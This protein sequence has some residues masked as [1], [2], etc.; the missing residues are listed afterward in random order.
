MPK[1]TRPSIDLEKLPFI[2]EVAR[3]GR[4]YNVAAEE[5]GISETALRRVEA[6]EAVTI[7]TIRKVVDWTAVS[8]TIHPRDSEAEEGSGAFEEDDGEDME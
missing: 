5:A 8:V 3:R 6:G 7:R 1:N 4:A 2:V